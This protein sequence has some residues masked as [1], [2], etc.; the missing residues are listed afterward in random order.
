M[1]H[2][3]Y[4]NGEKNVLLK[5]GLKSIYLFVT[6]CK[7]QMLGGSAWYYMLGHN[8]RSSKQR[9]LTELPYKVVIK[10]TNLPQNAFSTTNSPKK[11]AIVTNL[12]L[13]FI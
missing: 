3:L 9:G 6:M 2:L 8:N 4:Y 5:Y 11:V 10:A 1:S 7:I 12:G 13:G